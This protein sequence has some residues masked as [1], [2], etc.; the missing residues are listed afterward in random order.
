MHPIGI[1]STKNSLKTSRPRSRENNQDHCEKGGSIFKSFSKKEQENMLDFMY[2]MTMFY[3]NKL[4][5]S[6]VRYGAHQGRD[7]EVESYAPVD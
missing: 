7:D 6:S 3:S 1:G 4:R 2:G 5:G